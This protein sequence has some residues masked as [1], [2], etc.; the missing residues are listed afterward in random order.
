MILFFR[1]VSL[2]RCSGGIIGCD[3]LFCDGEVVSV[4][5]VLG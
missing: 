2:M 1:F 3:V 5:V 4:E